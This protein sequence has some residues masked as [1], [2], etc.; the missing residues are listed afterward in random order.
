MNPGIASL[1]ALLLDRTFGEPA[2]LHPL[3][4]FGAL[5]QQVES[6]ARA[7]ASGA[8]DGLRSRGALAVVALLSPA[9]YLAMLISESA[10]GIPFDILVLYLALGQRSLADHGRAVQ[11][12]LDRQDVPAARQCVSRLVTRDTDAM[13]GGDIAR[14]TVESMLE[15]G[16]DAVYGALFWFAVAG[17]PGVVVYRLANTLDAMWGYRTDHYLA[18]GWAAARFDDLLNLL[19]A[20]LSALTY[21]LLGDRRQAL[22]AW[23]EQGGDWG[24]PNAGP[25]M[26]AGAGALGVRLGGTASYHGEIRQRPVLGYGRDPIAKDIGRAVRLVANGAWV[27]AAGILVVTGIV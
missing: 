16:C 9:A 15:N 27:W 22:R 1:V 26:A 5:A 13:D 4:G 10:L 19:P 14:A 8:S 23:R 20:R 6:L 7:G 2:R 12:A 17:A 3:V 24:S 11:A 21:A 25:V 18:F